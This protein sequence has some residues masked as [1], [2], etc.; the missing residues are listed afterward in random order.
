MLK[1]ATL[2]AGV[3]FAAA[4]L[5]DAGMLVRQFGTLNGVGR[6]LFVAQML[7]GVLRDAALLLFFVALYARQ[8]RPGA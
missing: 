7:L 8:R 1:T 3:V 5:W 2:V 4:L 6:G